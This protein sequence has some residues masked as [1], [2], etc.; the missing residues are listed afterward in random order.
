MVL[1]RVSSLNFREIEVALRRAARRH[2]AGIS[3][4]EPPGTG[5]AF[6]LHQQELYD[7]L[8]A[9]DMRFSALVPCRIA[10]YPESGHVVLVAQSP[11]AFC[12]TL[13]RH[14]VENLAAAVETLLT[15]V[16]EEASKPATLAA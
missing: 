9:A 2:R 6:N 15:E 11:V 3:L 13:K 12:R 14:D 1:E 16:F 8:L 4:A 10:A 7:T 5:I